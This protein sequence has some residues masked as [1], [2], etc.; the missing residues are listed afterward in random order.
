LFYHIFNINQKFSTMHNIPKNKDSFIFLKKIL[1]VCLVMLLGLSPAFSQYFGRNKPSYRSFDFKVYESPNFTIY[2]YF[3]NDSVIH[4]VANSFEKWYIRHQKLFKDTFEKPSPIIVYQNHPEFQQTTAVGGMISVGTQGVTEALKNRVVIP[5]LETNAQTD[6]VIGHELVHVFHFRALFIDDS[7]SLNS[8]RNLPLWLVEG[9]AEYFS[10]GSVDANTS[11]IIRDAIKKNDFPTLNDM[12]RNYKYNPYRYGHSFVTFLGRTWGDSLIAPLFR[13]TAKFGYER[14]IER[15]IGLSA[16]T[17]SD[18]WRSANFAHFEEYLADSAR[19]QVIGEKLISDSNG[20]F[21]NISPSLSPDGK[22]IAFFSEK[23]LFSLDLYLADAETGRIM[24]KLSS[25]TRNA[26]IDAFNFF[27]SVGTWSPDGRKFVHVAVKRGQNQLVVVDTK[28]PRRTRNIAVPGVPALNNPAWSPDGRYLVFSGLVDGIGNLFM[29]DMQNNR[30]ER[31]TNDRYSYIHPS[32]SKDGRYLAFAT[33][34]LP[35]GYP[36]DT[37]NYTKYLG[38]MDMQAPGRPVRVL[39]VFPSATNINPVFDP[40]QKGLYFLSD[41]DGFRNLYY[42]DLEDEKAF[43]LTDYYT[44]VAGIT[45]LSPAISVARHTGEIVYSHYNDSKYFI[46]RATK[47]DFNFKEVDPMH[48]DMMAAT[49]PPLNRNVRPVVDNFFKRETRESVFPADSF[50]V[51]SFRPQFGLTFIGSSGVGASTSRF[52]TG[53]SGGV[54]MLFSDI[55]GFNQLYTMLAVNGE[56]YDFGGQVGYV[57]QRRR[58]NWGASASHIPYTYATLR[59][60][61]NVQFG[62]DGPIYEDLQFV[63]NRIFEDQ[64][65]LFA[66]YPISTTRRI[67]VGGSIAWYYFRED[68]FHNYYL[69]GFPVGQDRSRGTSPPGF[70]LQRMNIGYIGDNSYFGMASPMNGHRYRFSLEKY[71]GAID[72]YSAIADYRKYFFINPWSVAFRAVHY[73]RYGENSRNNFLYPLY[74]GYPGFLRGYDYNSLSRRGSTM[75]DSFEHL[76]GTRLLM[77]GLEFKV[78]FTGPER[79]ALISSGF[80]FT[81]LAWFLDAGV[82][83]NQ[84]Q[85]IVWDGTNRNMNQHRYPVFSTGPSLRINLFGALILEPYYAW[86]FSSLGSNRGVWGLN[87]LPGW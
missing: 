15:V 8:L 84:G 77:G 72:M 61:P 59:Y 70:N 40:E 38:I 27:E 36:T 35:E 65:G 54:A 67:E 52:G 7:L 53:M 46:Y 81:E 63:V 75:G 71:F 3:E 62:E 86:T 76:L 33:D 79:L 24:R 10:I 29:F 73:G 82:A 42:Y 83:W 13:E 74:L 43:Q 39:D 2:H 16:T 45:M 85:S 48:I 58:I 11:M 60:D 55:I 66:F 28:R 12:T 21:M 30:V 1:I 4:G 64:V 47:D 56:I 51:K 50:E 87:F 23:D 9:M 37:V 18:L 80:F 22:H 5:I 57:N 25:T 44:G 49:I 41:R 31:L 78:P 17:V 34:L 69:G 19:H 68:I 20:G 6:H 14:A 32:W 26:D